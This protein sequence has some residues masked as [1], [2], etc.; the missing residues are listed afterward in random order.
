MRSTT[1]T[2]EERRPHHH[3]DRV[4][5]D[6]AW[7]GSGPADRHDEPRKYYFEIVTARRTVFCTLAV[8][9]PLRR[10]GDDAGVEDRVRTSTTRCVFRGRSRS[11]SSSSAGPTAARSTSL[12]HGDRSGSR[13]VTAPVAPRGSGRV[14]ERSASEK[15]TCSSWARIHGGA[16]PKF[17]EDAKRLVD[18]CSA[19]NRSGAVGATSTCA[20]STC[21]DQPGVHGRSGAD[22]RTPVSPSTTL[23]S[24][25]CSNQDNRTCA[26]CVGGAV[27][28]LEIS[29]NEEHTAEGHLNAHATRREH[30]YAEYLSC[31]SSR[32][33]SPRSA[34][35]YH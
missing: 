19:S 15:P 27:R 13:F 33:I 35:E 18:A 1:S 6:G 2:P 5:D 21:P 17:H 3:L 16:A 20:P 11:R 25:A 7:P 22:R 32:T 23:D 12:V 28:V 9:D 29:V 31:T 26:T 24:S 34:D 14:R 8:R 30:A 4:V 10:V